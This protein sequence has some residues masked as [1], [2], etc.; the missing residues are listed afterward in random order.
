[1]PRLEINFSYEIFESP[2]VK[3]KV[4]KIFEKTKK[5]FCARFDEIKAFIME[6]RRDV[7]YREISYDE[8]FSRFKEL[9][10]DEVAKIAVEK[11]FSTDNHDLEK[12]LINELSIELVETAIM[13]R[14]MIEAFSDAIIG[15]RSNTYFGLASKGSMMLLLKNE[16]LGMNSFEKT[17][18]IDNIKHVTLVKNE[19]KS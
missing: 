14:T 19:E 10:F 5:K 17:S 8:V 6:H 12:N 7:E 1:M 4:D 11:A 16:F 15:I 3:Q 2:K 13:Q 9:L 18:S